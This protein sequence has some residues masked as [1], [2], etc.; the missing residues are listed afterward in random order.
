MSSEFVLVAVFE[1]NV[2]GGIES[3]EPS[4]IWEAV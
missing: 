3:E 2:S 1:G 4:S